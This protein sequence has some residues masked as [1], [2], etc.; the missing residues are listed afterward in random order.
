MSMGAAWV[1]IIVYV[2]ILFISYV[3]IWKRLSFLNE[4]HVR[5]T[6]V[7]CLIDRH[8]ILL[9]LILAIYVICGIVSIGVI[10]TF[11]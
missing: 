10:V 1:L 11:F 3:F 4:R 7:D 9:K 8:Y 6:A 2:L 5:H